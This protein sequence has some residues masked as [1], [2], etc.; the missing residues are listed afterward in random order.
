MIFQTPT[1]IAF[2]I[3]DDWWAFAEM[4]K[5]SGIGGGFYF[6]GGQ[7]NEHLAEVVELRDV[8]PPTR[9]TGVA[10]FKKYKLLPILF[11]FKSPECSLPPVKV[12]RL[13]LPNGYSYRVTNG[14]HRYYASAA[15]GYTKLP[16]IIQESD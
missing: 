6:F 14:V 4:E 5:F 3:P 13:T 8:E 7:P 11:A 2:D 16:V 15:V 10:L 12:E 1:G 9:D